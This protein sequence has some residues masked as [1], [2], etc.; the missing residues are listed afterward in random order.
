MPTPKGPQES[1]TA[2]DVRSGA[3]TLASMRSSGVLDKQNQSDKNRDHF[4]PGRVL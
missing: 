1:E 3:T 2:A 4:D